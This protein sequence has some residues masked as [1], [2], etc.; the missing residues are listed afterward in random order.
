M[1]TKFIL[2]LL[3]TMMLCGCYA[4]MRLYP[5]KGALAEQSPLPSFEAKITA[6]GDISVTLNDGEHFK[7]SW[8]S[9]RR[10][11]K[12]DAASSA[13]GN[14]PKSEMA[15]VWDAVYGQ[16]YFIAHVLGTYSHSRASIK[17]DRGTTL[18][19]EFFNESEGGEHP[20]PGKGVAK[21]SRGNIYKGVF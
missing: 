18:T 1:K 16:G 6:T 17:G 7:G 9:V 10:L 14:A 15:E 21:D 11:D 3:S 20:R 2:A 19:V 13:S 4:N 5:V 12:A 8:E